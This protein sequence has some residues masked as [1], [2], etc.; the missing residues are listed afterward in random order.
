MREIVDKYFP[1][2]W[3]I[4]IYMGFTVNLIETWDSF[5]AAKMALD[6]TLETMNVKGYAS[7]Y[8][9][10]L[11]ELLK[12]TGQMLKEGAITSETLLR[13]TNKIVNV[14]RNCNV[15]LRWLMLHT[16]TRPNKTD[17]NKK[18]KQLRELV[19]AE[20]K[21]DPVHLFKLLLNTAQLELSVREMYKKL[22]AEKETKWDELKKES[23]NSLVE[24][25]EVFS[26]AK[27]LTRIEKNANLQRWFLEI[28][29]QVD[30]LEKESSASSRKIV[31][32]IQALEEVQEFHQL[33]NNMQVIQFLSET[34]KFLHQMIRNMNIKEDFLI[35][36]QM[37][38]DLSYA[39]EPIDSFT[40]IMQ[41]GI[42]REPT[43]VIKLRA[44]FLK[45]ASA[46][47]APLLR[48]N[49]AHSEDLM[50]VSQYYSRELEIYVRKVVQ[51]I[52]KMMFEKM[53]RIIE[54]QTSVLKELP[55][56]LEKDKLK[57]YA[58][59]DERFEFA[60]LTHSISVFSE[61]M[62]MMKST[63]VGVICLDPKKLLEDGIR[64]ELVLH[65]SKALHS[66]LT[67]TARPKQE[68]LEQR[69]QAL[70]LIMDGYKRSFEYIQDYV[71]INGLKIWQEEVT[72]IVNFNVEQ[73]C[74]GFLRTKVH[75]W[76]S[77]YQSRYVPIPYYAPTDSVSENFIGRLAR[78]VI[79]S[80]DPR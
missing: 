7:S 39:W 27:P 74:N 5:K 19:V 50:S 3:I 18:T 69:L 47:E 13:D 32:L 36:L 57:E 15:V 64:K 61:G 35:T 58:Q 42:K 26:G 28:S 72:R 78:E 49:Q 66:E 30:S 25:S 53:A 23:Y 67:F 43:I 45:L 59:L 24:L 10:N 56:R 65:I 60:E 44:I 70:G 37:V 16:T 33:E 17:K 20:T 31:Q 73:E 22:L 21:H 63:L 6:N 34:R 55:T 52:P 8:G 11:P 80:T 2:N 62:R 79:R 9:A 48:I 41:L 29:K 14:L 1:D 38:G 51:I 40:P 71:N 46:L 4:S 77:A 75:S 12:T 68:E 54:I 76:Q